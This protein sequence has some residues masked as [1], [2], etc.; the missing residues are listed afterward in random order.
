MAP[1][2]RRRTTRE[3][4][5]TRAPDKQDP[6]VHRGKRTGRR[7]DGVPLDEELRD[8]QGL[9]L[10]AYVSEAFA[11]T[12]TIDVL[13]V[14]EMLELDTVL[15]EVPDDHEGIEEVTPPAPDTRHVASGED[16][17]RA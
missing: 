10:D 6:L 8:D 3:H 1:D 17:R 12:D 9:L 14:P 2:K 5:R 16:D 7:P 11:E 13:D 15:E 4:G